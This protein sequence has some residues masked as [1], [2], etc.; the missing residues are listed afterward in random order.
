M[1][2]SL[3]PPSQT[4]VLTAVA[5][6]MHR[7]D[8]T[9][10]IFDDW[11]AEGLA[12]DD[13]NRITQYLRANVPPEHV[14]AFVRWVGAR[15]RFTEDYVEQALAGGTEQY[16]ILGAGL[17]SFAYRRR[18]LLDRLHVFEVD[19][20]ASQAWKRSRLDALGVEVP[21]RLDFVP[22]DFER[23][24]LRR[25]LEQC[26]FD[27]AVPAIVSWIGVTMYLTRDAIEATL[28][29][30]AGT[31]AGSKVVLTYN[32]P[33]ELLDD[34]S[35]EVAR[36]LM[37]LAEM[38]GEPFV[39]FFAP[40]DV[41]ALLHRHGFGLVSDVGPD[42]A[43]RAYFMDDGTVQIAGAQRLASGTLTAT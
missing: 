4:A 5:R 9:P 41:E 10:V 26:G 29:D 24:T 19:H 33:R 32:Q 14:A 35:A 30:L 42:E 13:A 17:D 12:G 16:V 38:W 20:P 22:V 18:D 34:L 11:L 3:R 6:A 25:A 39:S 43:R 7:S 27:F 37:S 40:H 23:S 1:E 28:A 21:A 2:T 15:S 36:S 8:Q 31:A